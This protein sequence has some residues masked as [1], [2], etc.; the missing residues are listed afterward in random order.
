ML[1]AGDFV[2]KF[3]SN[4]TPGSQVALSTWLVQD[5]FGLTPTVNA[6]ELDEYKLQVCEDSGYVIEPGLDSDDVMALVDKLEAGELD[7]KRL[8]VFG[9]S[10]P[11]SVMHELRQNLKSLRSGQVVSVIERY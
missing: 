8:V 1:L 5:G 4:G 2:S 6:V 11:F 10:V 7:L 9:Y 3:A